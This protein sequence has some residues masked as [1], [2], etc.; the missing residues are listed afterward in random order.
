MEINNINIHGYQ[1]RDFD[2]KKK[3]DLFF[4]L[5]NLKKAT[6]KHS[7]YENELYLLNN[8]KGVY[9][10]NNESY[11]ICDIKKEEEYDW[12]NYYYYTIYDCIDAVPLEEYYAK[13]CDK[14]NEY[15]LN[16]IPDFQNKLQEL[17]NT[18]LNNPLHYYQL[19]CYK[20]Y[21]SNEKEL[22][23]FVENKMSNKKSCLNVISNKDGINLE[24]G[25]FL[26]NG[27]KSLTYQIFEIALNAKSITD[28][29]YKIKNGYLFNDEYFQDKETLINYLEQNFKDIIQKK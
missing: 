15:I 27:K 18:I 3:A 17:K 28:K 25:D 10:S 19:E 14:C 22:K 1:T 5:A 13:N 7:L 8:E 16:L 6:K 23:F 9:L 29:I 11:I 21:D 2:F 12:I 26:F 20:K 24:I 4:D